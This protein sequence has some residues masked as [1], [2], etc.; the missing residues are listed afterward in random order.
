MPLLRMINEFRTVRALLGNAERIARGLGEELPGAE[1]L[2]LSALELPD[3]TARR[4][5]E[6]LGRSPDGLPAAIAAQHRSAL[7]SVGIVVEDEPAPTPLP[8]ARG[9]FRS[10]PAAQAA[11]RRAVELSG[12]PKPRRLLGAHVLL[13]L[14]EQEHGTVARTLKAMGIERGALADAARAVLPR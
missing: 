9:A 7:A 8:N 6:R 2:L 14:S 1:H 11:F 10:T 4:A 5:F 13:A 3:G 12:T